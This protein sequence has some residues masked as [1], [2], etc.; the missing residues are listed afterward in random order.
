MKY[1]FTFISAFLV[2]SNVFCQNIKEEVV[3]F[4]LLK[5]PKLHI[6]E[7]S[8]NYQVIVTSPYNVTTESIIENSKKEFV[9]EEKAYDEKLKQSEVEFGQK[10]KDYEADVK[11][12]NQKYELESA[13]FKKLSMIERLA[14]TDQGKNPKL[15][16]PTK[17]QYYKPSP[18]VYREPNLNDYSIVNN[19][20]LASQINIAGFSKTGNFLQ[21]K[22]DIERVNFQDN[23]G[24]TYANQPTRVKVFEG[25][26]EILN[27]SFFTE[28]KFINSSPSN[29]INKPL[30]EKNHLNSVITAINNFLNEEL[31]Y[32]E[33]PK[34]ITLEVVK[35]KGEYNDL[36]K[37]N[38]YVTTNL[39]K[40]QPQNPT[41]TQKAFEGIQKG[42]DIWEE[43]LKKVD[44]KNKKSVF[45]RE[46]ARYVYFNLIKLNLALENKLKAE[47]YLN[48]LQEN[49]VFMDLSSN[50]KIELS[51]LENEIY[52]K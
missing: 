32:Q 19:D 41:I 17:P 9:E 11:K 4:T 26:K 29:N 18:P 22:V 40:I 10:I 33:I 39:K 44:Y 43:T 5:E 14:M 7:G 3:N 23:A 46:I 1:L 24:Q 30:A 35:N 36:E 50:E 28:F 47:N 34:I 25:T 6:P 2:V 37:A 52:K 21:V 48:E 27:K 51:K 49:I 16:L 42:V 13:E 12:A 8:R 38:I 45:N 20:V 15:V 31:G